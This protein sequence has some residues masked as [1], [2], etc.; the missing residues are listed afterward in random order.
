M[1]WPMR[2]GELNVKQEQGYTVT[3]LLESLEKLW[4]SAFEAH[5]SITRDQLQVDSKYYRQGSCAKSIMNN[6]KGGLDSWRNFHQSVPNRVGHS[7]LR[8]K[9]V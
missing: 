6:D 1:V 5:L 7:Y 4:A 8:S 9:S 2:Y 3:S